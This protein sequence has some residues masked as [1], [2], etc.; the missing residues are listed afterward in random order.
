MVDEL[1][2]TGSV[3]APAGS[4][5]A[6]ENAANN[7][8][9]LKFYGIGFG[10]VV[11]IIL[12]L[13]I[14]RNSGDSGEL[15]SQEREISA[16]GIDE[17]V[18]Q[19]REIEL[20]T[21]VDT[22]NEPEISNDQI[23]ELQAQVQALSEIIL[24]QEIADRSTSTGQDVDGVNELIQSLDDANAQII[25]LN[26]ELQVSAQ[27]NTELRQ[28]VAELREQIADLALQE[29]KLTARYED[30]TSAQ[31]TLLGAQAARI[32][33]LDEEV[34][35]LLS[36]IEEMDILLNPAVEEYEPLYAIA[37]EYPDRAAQRGLEGWALVEF[38]V[39]SNGA[40]IEDTIRV[41]DAEPSNVFNRSAIRAASQFEFQPRTE[42]GVP[43]EVPNVKY[44]FRFQLED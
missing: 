22:I 12:V 6:D 18:L 40:V 30:E 36:Q 11:S 10:V 43:V 19:P 9:L 42:N 14:F 1:K 13:L 25:A 32:G 23:L 29:S 27:E 4:A 28:E 34:E 41:V 24:S 7:K 35:Q 31:A 33:E 5:L 20:S 39:D 17:E 21:E 2:A 38:T 8:L 37:P 16:V 44:L 15:V 3:Q 26:T